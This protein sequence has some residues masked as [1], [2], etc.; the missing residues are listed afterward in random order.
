M[1][2]QVK[3]GPWD[4]FLGPDFIASN[5]QR[6]FHGEKRLIFELLGR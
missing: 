2:R 4:R 5:E 6:H 3:K 1:I